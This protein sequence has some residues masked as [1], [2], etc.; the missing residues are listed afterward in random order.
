MLFNGARSVN[1]VK[2]YFNYVNND[3]VSMNLICLNNVRKVCLLCDSGNLD[4]DLGNYLD[5]I[6][7][8]I[9]FLFATE[10]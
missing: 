2:Y 1:L 5:I 7:K 6:E 9:F 3:S 8:H 4:L 10:Q